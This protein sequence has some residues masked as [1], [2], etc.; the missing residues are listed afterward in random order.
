MK[1][2]MKY[3]SLKLDPDQRIK[4]PVNP[5]GIVV[6]RLLLKKL[7]AMKTAS[8]NL[9][10]LDGCAYNN[11]EISTRRLAARKSVSPVLRC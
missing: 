9:S 11:P 1:M 7:T 6:L 10:G 2:T 5:W 8:T 3:L 4:C